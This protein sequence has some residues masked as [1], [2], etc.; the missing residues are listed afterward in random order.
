MFPIL[1]QLGPITIHTYGV[2]VAGGI[3][4]GLF[5][6]RRTAARFGLDPERAWNLGIYMVLAGLLGAKLWYVAANWSY[7]SANPREIFA[8]STL[9]SAG[10]FYGGFFGGV[11]VATIYLWRARMSLLSTL[12]T[13]AAPLALGHAVGRLGCFFAGCCWGKPTSSFLG[14]TFT[15]LYVGQNIGTPLGIPIHPTQLYEAAAEFLMFA[16][17]WWYGARRKFP[18]QIFAAY[19]I[20]YGAVRFTNEF[21]RGDP[22]RTMMFNNTLSLMQITSVAL[23]ALGVWLYLR[24]A[25]RPASS[26]PQIEAATAAAKARGPRDRKPA[27]AK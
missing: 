25:R 2:L 27:R 13:Y 15:N 19:A 3:L 17:L 22:G 21:F 14:V 11:L 18:G 8:F 9:Q 1:I 16:F 12:D 26:E 24:G 4:F 7:Y 20:L 6:G 5:L 10:T 23:M